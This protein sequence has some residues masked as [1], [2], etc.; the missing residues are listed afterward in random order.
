LTITSQEQAKTSLSK[1]LPG[2]K[3]KNYDVNN[4]FHRFSFKLNRFGGDHIKENTLAFTVAG[5]SALQLE[6]MADRG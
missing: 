2:T 4:R 5:D 1:T 6:R 3:F